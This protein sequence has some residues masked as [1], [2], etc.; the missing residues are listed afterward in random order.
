MNFVNQLIEAAHQ[1]NEAKNPDL[2]LGK[3]IDLHPVYAAMSQ[4]REAAEATGTAP[5]DIVWD[6]SWPELKVEGD[7]HWNDLIDRN[8]ETL[9]RWH[10]MSLEAGRKGTSLH[11]EIREGIETVTEITAVPLNLTSEIAPAISTPIDDAPLP[12]CEMIRSHVEMVHML[13]KSA[14]VDGVLTLTRI[15][16]KDKIFTE[17]FSIGD[18][19]NHASAVIGWSSHPGL[20][21]YTPR[22]IFRKDL[23]R[24]SKGSEADVVATLAF[25]GDLDADTGKSGTG[26]EKLPL[27]SPYVMETSEGNYQPVF[28][29]ARALSQSEAKPIAVA[30]GNAIGA[31]SRT[32]DTS[33]LFR[34][35]GTLNWP[36]KKKLERGRSPVPQFSLDKDYLDRRTC[37]VR[38]CSNSYQRFCES[39]QKRCAGQRIETADHR[40]F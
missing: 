12:N 33:S 21:L 23:P 10:A 7:H 35:A 1:T 24:W 8:W 34:I 2:E 38:R 27:A 9:G 16:D 20:N 25:V 14:G 13:A 11:I 18:V 19:E 5:E 28:P 22:A 3:V 39:G 6:P 40:N 26:L 31:D 15:D 30:L 36:S 29:L 32:K 17:R 4:A 37:R